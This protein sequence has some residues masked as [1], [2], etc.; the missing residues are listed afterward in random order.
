MTDDTTVAGAGANPAEPMSRGAVLW[1]FVG[2][3]VS[4]FMFSLNQTVLATALPTIVGELDGWDSML[5]VST[6]FML[7]STATMPA[8]GKIGDLF[9][10]KPLFLVAISIFI[11]G[12]V[13]ALFA[14]SMAMLITGRVFQGLGGEGS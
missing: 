6:A 10:R 1:V 13:I 8:Y 7:A 2:L 11:L 9:G 5:W 3:L 12:S 4:M 14:D